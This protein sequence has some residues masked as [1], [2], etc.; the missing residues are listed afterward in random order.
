MVL[1][2]RSEISVRSRVSAEVGVTK[3][4]LNK[5]SEEGLSGDWCCDK[6]TNL[7]LIA[8]S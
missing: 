8:R 5:R 6:H 7:A 1:L 4:I 2:K 3:T